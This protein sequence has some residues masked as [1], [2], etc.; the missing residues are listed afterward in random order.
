MSFLST[1]KISLLYGCIFGLFSFRSLFF[2]GL[3]PGDMG[4]SRA[5]TTTFEHWWYFFQGKENFFDLLYFAP[6]KNTLGGSE[7]FFLQGIPYSVF[8]FSGL[9]EIDSWVLTNIL[10]VA[11]GAVG[12]FLLFDLIFSKLLITIC[13]ALLVM[14]SYQM[15]TQ[16]A[17]PQTFG[18]LLISWWFYYAIRIFDE[19]P[20]HKSLIFLSLWSSLLL[21]GSWYGFLAILLIS[22]CILIFGFIFDPKQFNYNRVRLARNL[23]FLWV[24]SKAKTL[25]I[26]FP[27][28]SLS[29]FIAIYWDRMKDSK[30]G[31]FEEVIFYSPRLFDIFNAS[32]NAIGYSAEFYKRANLG[33]SETFE[34]S[35]GFPLV[36][37]GLIVI[38][39]LI[40]LFR[41]H[42]L[43]LSTKILTMCCF[44]ITLIPIADERGL[45]LW[46]FLWLFPGGNSV[47]TPARFWVFVQILWVIVLMLMCRQ[48]LTNSLISK[49]LLSITL[50]VVTSIACYDQYRPQKANWNGELLTA[51]G[52]EAKRV[53]KNSN[54]DVFYLGTSQDLTISESLAKQIDGMVIAYDLGIP[55]VNGYSSNYPKNWPQTGA[56]GLVSNEEAFNWVA[57]H[58]GNKFEN[59]CYYSES[60]LQSKNVKSQ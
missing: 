20:K 22:S 54:C 38:A 14:F 44:F 49:S 5:V 43:E 26:F 10:L 46:Y 29:L 40:F 6:E 12:L 28:L 3:Y 36:F 13:G 30:F 7:T 8:R 11:L 53:L 19:H 50:V 16:F 17:H 57:N 34:R 32:E 42:R 45:S 39:S 41:A 2:K 15:N 48:L 24:K 35:M 18:F 33:I 23:R 31:N 58:P 4:D 1:K 27:L 59:F 47:R 56:W 51:Y 55:T 9:S 21:L 25:V 37:A 52:E 60:G